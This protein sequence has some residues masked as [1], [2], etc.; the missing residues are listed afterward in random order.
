MRSIFISYRQEPITNKKYTENNEQN[1][2]SVYKSCKNNHYNS[3]D[4]YESLGY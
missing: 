3:Y 2:N 4:T 1:R